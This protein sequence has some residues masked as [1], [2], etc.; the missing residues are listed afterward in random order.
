MDP[1]LDMQFQNSPVSQEGPLYPPQDQD[2]DLWEAPFERW[3]RLADSLLG[4]VPPTHPI[5]TRKI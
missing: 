1:N 4:N 3:L 5:A 2:M